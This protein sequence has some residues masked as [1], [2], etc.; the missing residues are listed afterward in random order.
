MSNEKSM[1]GIT[2]FSRKEYD[3][4]Q[5]FLSTKKEWPGINVR[6]GKGKFIRLEWTS[7]NNI[8]DAF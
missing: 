2:V 8:S 6:T 4:H 3:N 7:K 1:K 5:K